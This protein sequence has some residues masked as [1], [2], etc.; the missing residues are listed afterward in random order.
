MRPTHAIGIDP[1]TSGAMAL[2]ERGGRLMDWANLPNCPSPGGGLVKVEIDP[3]ALHVLAA[4]WCDTHGLDIRST[5]ACIE[6][7]VPIKHALFALSQGDSVGVCRAIL[8]PMV[9]R[10]E[11]PHP[12]QWQ[13]LF[14]LNSEK[15]GHR[16]CA[17]R[18]FPN[19]PAKARHDVC[20]AA[21][22]AHWVLLDGFDS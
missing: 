6:R 16:E 8:A 10:I 13:R 17:R 4:G 15:N 11:R 21:L 22:M 1:G 2:V 20:D 5:V 14:G 9:R 19:L 12:Q 18:L 7:A 3:I